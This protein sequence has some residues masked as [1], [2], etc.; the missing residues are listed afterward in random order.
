MRKGFFYI[1][2]ALS[3]VRAN[4]RHY[5]PYLLSCVGTIA[6]FYIL[7]ALAQGNM[8]GGQFAYGA[9]TLRA[10]LTLGT[11]VVALFALLFLFYTHSF[12][13]KRRKQEFALYNIL[14]MEKKHVARVLFYETV[15]V[16]ISALGGGIGGGILL[17]KLAALLLLKLLGVSA[18]M[19]FEVPL[20]AVHLALIVFGVIFLLTFLSALFQ[21]HTVDPAQLLRGGRV[22]EKEP[23]A[24]WLIALLGVATLGAGYYLAVTIKDPIVALTFFFVAVVLVIIGTYCLFTAG[25]VTAL[26]LLRKNKRF[27]Y[28]TRNFV[29][30]SGMIYRMK[31]NAAGLA[32]ICILSTMLLVT[33]SSTVS[34]YV[35]KEDMV[36]NHYPRDVMA[37]GVDVDLD[38]L[39]QALKPALKR[40]NEQPRNAL[41]Y[42]YLEFGAMRSGDAFEKIERATLDSQAAK[43]TFIPIGD[44]ADALPEPA[45]LNDGEALILESN[46]FHYPHDRMS[47]LGQ[48]FA[49]RRMEVDD[50]ALASRPDTQMG[51]DTYMIAVKDMA[52]VRRI[53][54]LQKAAYGEKASNPRALYA[55]DLPEDAQEK[56]I[57][58]AGTIDGVM[59]D[60]VGDFRDQVSRLWGGMFFLGLLLGTLFLMATGSIIYYKQLS[61]GYDDRERYVILQNVGMSRREVR[62]AIRRQVL[63]VF[64][65]PL[66]A[67]GIHVSFAFPMIT[68]LLRVLSLTNVPL[69]ATSTAVSLAIF[70]ALYLAIYALTA[71]TYYKIV[72]AAERA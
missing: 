30:V 24:N 61:E 36:L 33:W 47:V 69:F 22:G 6:M 13:I 27:Y 66:I 1:K 58:A 54:A 25:S 70:A 59:L 8:I 4:R 53:D 17:S 38:K 19:G 7:S 12:L 52:V 55:F 11:W 39:G 62:A 46:G 44:I 28:K 72:S 45:Q 21:I 5:V 68:R 32:S 41:A 71:R 57:G 35:G 60:A 63:M 51:A 37:R 10:M 64:F 65:L 3:N 14:G 50:R 34:L 31:Q 48:A 15:C 40:L 67:A 42:N 9:D 43:L 16:A 18:V 49:V 20:G 56:L 2:L 23:K 26:K 29:P